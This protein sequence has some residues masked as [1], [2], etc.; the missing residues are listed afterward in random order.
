MFVFLEEAFLVP[1]SNKLGFAGLPK[2]PEYAYLEVA[3]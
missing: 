2:S 1:C 3:S